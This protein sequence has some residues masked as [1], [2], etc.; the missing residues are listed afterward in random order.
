MFCC[1][2]ANLDDATAERIRE[3][4]RGPLSW[5][6]A[7]GIAFDH[8]VDP[9][10]YG[11]LKF[12]GEALVPAVWLENMR[13]TARKSGGLA[14][15]YFAELLRICEIFDA[16]EIPLIPY[17]GPVL[18]WLAF[19]NLV[20][21]RFIDLDFFVPQKHLP[22]SRRRARDP[23]L[24]M[25]KFES[26]GQKTGRLRRASFPANT[27]FIGTPRKP[28]SNYTRSARYATFQSRWTLKK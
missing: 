6:D 22:K 27:V 9:F 19:G 23:W 24:L 17:K 28:A 10:L 18:S 3:I 4:L 12:A 21:R 26:P 15:M 14:V 1:A 7:V 20:R 13:N 5:P 8:H 2:H 25:R 16:Q 11:N